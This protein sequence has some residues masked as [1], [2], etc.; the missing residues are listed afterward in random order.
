MLVSALIHK[1]D[2]DCLRD[3][4]AKL[5]LVFEVHWMLRIGTSGIEEF[6]VVND[7]RVH[8]VNDKRVHVLSRHFTK[9]AVSLLVDIWSPVK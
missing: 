7:K 6:Q 9:A 5:W 4:M 1:G 2:Q 3:S 8:V